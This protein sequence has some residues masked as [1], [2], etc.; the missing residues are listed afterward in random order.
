MDV[1]YIEWINSGM[2]IHIVPK[3]ELQNVKKFGLGAVSP[4]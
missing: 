1:E 4:Y 3:R 2:I